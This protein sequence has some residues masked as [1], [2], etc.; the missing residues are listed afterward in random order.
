MSVRDKEMQKMLSEHELELKSLKKKS[1]ASLE[2][3]R[4]DQRI[5]ESKVNVMLVS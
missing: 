2:S 5:A 4:N 1:D 3:L